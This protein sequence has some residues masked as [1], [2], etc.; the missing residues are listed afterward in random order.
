MGICD[1]V[2]AV[3][4]GEFHNGRAEKEKNFNFQIFRSQAFGIP[5][6][7]QIKIWKSLEGGGWRRKLLNIFNGRKRDDLWPM[8]FLASNKDIATD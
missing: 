3:A 1:R 6:N 8:C 7:R 5:R 2:P 4:E